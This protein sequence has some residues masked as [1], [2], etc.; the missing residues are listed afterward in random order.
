MVTRERRCFCLVFPGEAM[1]V[2]LARGRSF[3]CAS[4]DQRRV[5]WPE[6]VPRISPRAPS[7]AA[8]SARAPDLRCRVARM[9]LALP[10]RSPTLAHTTQH[11][12]NPPRWATT[13]SRPPRSVVVFRGHVAPLPATPRCPRVRGLCRVEG[14]LSS[15]RGAAAPPM[16][17]CTMVAELAP[18]PCCPACARC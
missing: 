12:P 1:L 5:G 4:C 9:Q 10:C 7:A 18:S 6:R 3:E 8:K 16:G 2:S 14:Q 11:T 15:A 17:H 13:T